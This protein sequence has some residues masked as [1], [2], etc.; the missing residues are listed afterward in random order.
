ME[1]VVLGTWSEKGAL[2]ARVGPMFCN[3]TMGTG[4]DF[5][6]RAES[7]CDEAMSTPGV[8]WVSTSGA[9]WVGMLDMFWAGAGSVMGVGGMFCAGTEELSCDEVVNKGGAF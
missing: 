4:G 5:C 7:S 9:F 6:A 1:T 2:G 8:F 3:K